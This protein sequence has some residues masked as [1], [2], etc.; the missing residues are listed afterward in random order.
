MPNGWKLRRGRTAKMTVPTLVE[1]GGRARS[2]K[3]D[4]ASAK[5]IRPHLVTNVDRRSRLQTDEFVTYHRLGREFKGGHG[6]VNHKAEQYRR[7]ADYTNTVEGFFSIFKR[8]MKGVY[9]HCGESHLHR[10]LTEFD[11][12]YSHRKAL[13]LDDMDT[14][15]AALKGIQ[16]R[17]LTYRRTNEA[18]YS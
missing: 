14:T 13:G 1:R 18:R 16:G 4:D 10:Y 11:F 3:V 15:K 6:T 2:F 7:G 17:R 9:Q 8:G 5:S 12:R